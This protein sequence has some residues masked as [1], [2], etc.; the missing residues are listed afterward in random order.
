MTTRGWLTHHLLAVKVYC[1]TF[2][3]GVSREFH[4]WSPNALQLLSVSTYLQKCIRQI[5]IGA[6]QSRGCEC[7]VC[8][9]TQ[10]C[11]V[12]GNITVVNECSLSICLTGY[13]GLHWPSFFT[14]NKVSSP[15]E[16]FKHL[17]ATTC[18]Q[19]LPYARKSYLVLIWAN[20]NWLLTVNCSVCVWNVSLILQKLF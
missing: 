2:Q 3:E 12:L 6:F 19:L 13:F 17:C 8:S 16:T 7:R 10:C 11:L 15:R 18:I 9:G 14:S 5:H 1:G 4:T 20:A